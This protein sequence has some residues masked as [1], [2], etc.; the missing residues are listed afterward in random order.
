MNGISKEIFMCYLYVI[1]KEYI[2][3]TFINY[4]KRKRV[5]NL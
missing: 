5:T 2:D 4:K 1:T 3:K